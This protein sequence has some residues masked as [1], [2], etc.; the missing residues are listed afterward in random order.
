M[1]TKLLLGVFLVLVLIIA[2]AVRAKFELGRNRSALAAL[3]SDLESLRKRAGELNMRVSTAKAVSRGLESDA[4]LGVVE[5]SGAPAIASSSPIEKN[6]AATATSP[7]VI[8]PT[9]IV[10]DPQMMA[11]LMRNVR[12]QTM[13]TYG[14]HLRALGLSPEQMERFADGWA[15]IE[16]TRREVQAAVAERGIRSGTAEWQK[17]VDDIEQLRIVKWTAIFGDQTSRFIDYNR[18]NDVRAYARELG[19]MSF[20]TGEIA[21]AAQIDRAGDILVA[22][23]QRTRMDSFP[24]RMMSSTI[25]WAAAAEQLKPVLSPRQIEFVRLQIESG[26]LKLKIDERTKQLTEQFRKQSAGR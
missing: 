20:V 2:F 9:I 11:D 23:C 25:N 15:E 14:P 3:A 7:R 1:K 5:P 26:N 19:T 18:S 21:T 4:A 6:T 16:R 13:M 10:N 22:N 8:G 12:D 24:D 17:L